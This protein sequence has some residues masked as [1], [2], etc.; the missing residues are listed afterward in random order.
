MYKWSGLVDADRRVVS[1]CDFSRIAGAVHRTDSDVVMDSAWYDLHALKSG[2]QHHNVRASSVR[3]KRSKL[4]VVCSRK[5]V[6]AGTYRERNSFD[7]S[8]SEAL[9]TCIARPANNL[10]QIHCCPPLIACSFNNRN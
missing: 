8:N 2:G 3:L 5:K 4:R 7:A 6:I 9:V 1:G 10:V